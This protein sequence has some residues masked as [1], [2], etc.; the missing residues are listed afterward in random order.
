MKEKQFVIG[1]DG[2]GSKT[3]AAAVS[4]DGTVLA[5]QKGNGINYHNIGMEKARENLFG[6]VSSLEKE[7]G[8][9]CTALSIGS[10]ALEDTASEK[11][12]RAFAGTLFRADRIIMESDAYMALIGLTQ[13]KP[14]MI[15]IC[16]TGSMLVMGGE[17]KQSIMGGWGHLL[18][19]PASGYAIALAGLRAAVRAWEGTARPTSLADKATRFF[20]LSENRQLTEKI[21]APDFGVDG[22]AKFAP[23]VFEAAEEGDEEANAILCAQMDEIAAEAAALL[24]QD[25]QVRLVGLYGGIFQHQSMAKTLFS[26]LLREKMPEREFEIAKP[27]YPPE[28]GAAILYFLRRGTLNEQILRNMQ[29][30]RQAFYTGER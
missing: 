16:G 17:K 30:S 21:Y 3:I 5:V 19:D 9:E 15:V 24:R 12:V 6:I 13:G 1:V 26:G 20:N 14:G 10:A 25:A 27:A 2:G 28:L 11:E 4:M 8:A 29:E 22:I 7:C 18:G 23:M